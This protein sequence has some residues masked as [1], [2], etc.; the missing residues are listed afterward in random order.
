MDELDNNKEYDDQID[1]RELF[2]VLWLNK[3]FIVILTTLA[4]LASVLYSLSL[5]NIYT[6]Q[7]LL[8]PTTSFASS[9]SLSQF[10]GLASMTGI[11]LPKGGGDNQLEVALKL[12][13]SKKLLDRLMLYESFLPDLLAAES[14]SMQT[15]TITYNQAL[16]DKKNNLWVRKASLPFK[17][18]PSSQEAF[19]KFSGLVS[20]SR[21]NNT[22][23]ITLTVNHLSPVV[24]QQWSLWIVKE[25]NAVLANMEI[26][27]SQASIDY[28]NSQ[29]KITP[30][31]ELRTM[32]YKLIQE[33]TQSM[34]LAS[35]NPEYVLST[36]DP[37]VIPEIKSGPKRSSIC[38]FWT[39]LGCMLSIL[40]VLVRK[41]AF[42]KDDE[43]NIF[44]LR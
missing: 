33:S 32:F 38:I 19:G 42:S 22:Q 36:I 43:L 17:Q 16:Y 34:M 2:A 18:I 21:D 39:L 24:A 7:T 10:S 13:K 14:W 6:A 5:T 28:L 4:A 23:L 40:I 3:K 15:N 20:I 31:S 25:V 11:N 1:P 44:R 41:Y 35:V 8:S 26:S 12:I 30:Y 37:P 9:N 27:N 29:I